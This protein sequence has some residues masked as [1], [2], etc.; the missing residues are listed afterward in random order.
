MQL[1]SAPSLLHHE[2]DQN[3]QRRPKAKLE[4]VA[5]V[6]VALDGLALLGLLVL[7]GEV[8]GEADDDEHDGDLATDGSAESGEVLGE[9][10]LAVCG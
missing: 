10:L 1:S 5:E 2:L 8:E 9:V 4:G 7:A 3:E 6:G